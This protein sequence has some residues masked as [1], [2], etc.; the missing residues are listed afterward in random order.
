MKP[1]KT[2]YWIVTI[3]F[4]ALMLMD[5]FAGFAM[6]EDGKA[7]MQQL[8]YPNYI[9]YLVGAGKVL[10]AIAILQTRYRT[11]KEWA[12]AGFTINFISAAVSWAIVGAPI[13]Y[14]VFPLIMLAVM[15]FTY[16]IWK[17]YERRSN[18]IAPALAL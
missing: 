11:I 15:F 7:A 10:G 2:L 5:G 3:I 4:A 8:G 18:H 6:T 13:A 16:Y 14:S 1:S 12:Y 17:R 9:M